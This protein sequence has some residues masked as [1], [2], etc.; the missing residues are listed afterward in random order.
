[1]KQIWQKFILLSL[2]QKQKKHNGMFFSLFT[3]PMVKMYISFN[4][5]AI[6]MLSQN[7]YNQVSINVFFKKPF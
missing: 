3:L 7:I 2:P 4:T 6:T 5:S 1:M